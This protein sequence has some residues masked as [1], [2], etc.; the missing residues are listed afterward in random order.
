MAASET[1]EEGR[2]G[3]GTL[4]PGQGRGGLVLSLLSQPLCSRFLSLSDK[5]QGHSSRTRLDR[6]RLKSCMRELVRSQ[7]D[8]PIKE[9][10]E[11]GTSLLELKLTP[12]AECSSHTLPNRRAWD[13][14]PRA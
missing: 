10:S 5:D 2:V 13:S 1:H 8:P 14:R 7:Q 12:K 4:R 6:E 11:Q 9:A 3:Q